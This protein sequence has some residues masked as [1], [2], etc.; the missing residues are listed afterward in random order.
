[1]ATVMTM[2]WPEVT[3]EQYEAVRAD[4]KWETNVPKGA[5]YHVSWFDGGLHVVDVWDSQADFQTFV[6]DRLGPAVAKVGIQSQPNVSF[7]ETHAIFAP[8][9]A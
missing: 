1:M 9:P 4:V 6:Q 3:K 2:H 8:N 7:G 5:K